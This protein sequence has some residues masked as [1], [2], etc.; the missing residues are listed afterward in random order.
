MATWTFQT[1]TILE[2]PAGNKMPFI[3]ARLYRGISIVKQNGSY[4]RVRGLD[5]NMFPSYSEY[6]LGGTVS[7]VTDAVKAALIAGGVGID[8]TNFT[9]V[10]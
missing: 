2:G 7:V 9:L 6:Y 4:S 8:S 10:S 1:P 5:A 3:R